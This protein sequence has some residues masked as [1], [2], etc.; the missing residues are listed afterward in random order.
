MNILI[1]YAHLMLKS[2]YNIISSLKK[3]EIENSLQVDSSHPTAP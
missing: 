1:W 2:E 3:Q